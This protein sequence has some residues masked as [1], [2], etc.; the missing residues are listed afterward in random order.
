[1][2]VSPPRPGRLL[3][4]MSWDGEVWRATG[5]GASWGGGAGKGYGQF[6]RWKVLVN[7]PAK[8]MKRAEQ[9]LNIAERTLN[10]AEKKLTRVGSGSIAGI[11]PARAPGS[12]MPQPQAHATATPLVSTQTWRN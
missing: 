10:L 4:A 12:G 11:A 8:R 7:E 1:M 9:L 5:S 2:K 6:Q 3:A